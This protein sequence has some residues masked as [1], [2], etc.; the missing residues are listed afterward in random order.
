M[1]PKKKRKQ[2]PTKKKPKRRKLQNNSVVSGPRR[3]SQRYQKAESSSSKKSVTQNGGSSASKRNVTRSST[4]NKAL[5]EVVATVN[6][7]L[8][9]PNND[10]AQYNPDNR[11]SDSSHQESSDG[12][13]IDAFFTKHGLNDSEDEED[14]EKSDEDSSDNEEDNEKLYH[15]MDNNKK[16]TKIF[17]EKDVLLPRAKNKRPPSNYSYPIQSIKYMKDKIGEK[18]VNEYFSLNSGERNSYIMKLIE[19]IVQDKTFYKYDEIIEKY[20]VVDQSHMNTLVTYKIRN[21]NSASRF[22]AKKYPKPTSVTN[23]GSIFNTA[24]YVDKRG[25]MAFDKIYPNVQVAKQTHKWNMFSMFHS[26]HQSFSIYLYNYSHRLEDNELVHQCTKIKLMFPEFAN[27]I[28]LIHGRLVH[29]GAESKEDGPLSFNWSHDVRMFSYLSSFKDHE[30]KRELYTNFSENNKVVR[31][32][33]KVC[34]KN[35]SHCKSIRNT[36]CVNDDRY[37]EIDM[38]VYID[39]YSKKRNGET[40]MATHK[41]RA[42]TKLLGSM[43]KLGWEVHTGIQF[44]LSKYQSLLPQI[45]ECVRGNG[46]TEWQGI[47]GTS[48]CA[49]KIDHL[50][51]DP[52]KKKLIEQMPILTKAYDDVCD[53]VL[54][55]ISYLG[56]HVEM[57]GRSLLAN[58]AQVDEQQPHRDFKEIR[59]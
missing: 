23:R 3:R 49:F 19:S 36:M 2:T 38:G 57:E 24:E 15:E 27:C 17:S 33:F 16:F 30:R 1:A 37:Q 26:L 43:T 22:N 6:K 29:S 5:V 58:M 12:D 14:I 47:G 56:D 54:R 31:H 4:R 20:I 8:N 7:D 59:K 41:Q 48:R 39:E 25:Y 34:P 42:P 45:R 51:A 55:K 44:S 46:S 10:F 13:S 50:L 35:C 11:T 53:K 52:T 9:T 28:L 18:E 40:I 21:H 32:T